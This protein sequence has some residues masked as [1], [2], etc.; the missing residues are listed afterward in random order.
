MSSIPTDATKDKL[1]KEFDSVVDQT[2]D[3][4]RAVSAAGTEG[5]DTLKASV[6]SAARATDD[7]VNGNPW[8]AVGMVAGLAAVAGLLAG[9]LIA[10]R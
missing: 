6:G 1:A 4:L 7:Y 8:R 10:R 3:L 5:A 9:L 2:Q